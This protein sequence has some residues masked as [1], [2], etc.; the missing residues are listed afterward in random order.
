MLQQYVD[1]TTT[2]GGKAEKINKLR[3]SL[4]KN[5]CFDP[6]GEWPQLKEMVIVSPVSDEG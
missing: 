6:Y 5:P 2:H 3:E 4:A 1:G